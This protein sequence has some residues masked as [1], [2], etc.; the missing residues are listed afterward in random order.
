MQCMD[1]DS[2]ERDVAAAGTDGFLPGEPD[3]RPFESAFARLVATA[4]V[5]GI[6]TAI[7]AIAISLDAAGWVAGLIVSCVTV[8]LAAILWRSRRL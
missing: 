1:A 8:A 2:N 7:G 6:G 4:G 3:R 5:V